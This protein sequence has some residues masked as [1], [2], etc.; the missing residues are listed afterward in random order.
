MSPLPDP[1]PILVSYIVSWN[2]WIQLNFHLWR[3]RIS[4]PAFFICFCCWK[5]L[6]E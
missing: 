5:H 3:G 6:P 4:L 2:I 1:V